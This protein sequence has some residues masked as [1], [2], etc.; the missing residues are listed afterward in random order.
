[1][2]MTSL[3]FRVTQIQTHLLELNKS[4]TFIFYLCKLHFTFLFEGN[5]TWLKFRDVSKILIQI[6]FCNTIFNTLVFVSEVEL[7]C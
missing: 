2:G 5:T 4:F 7:M 6:S 1:M 3:I